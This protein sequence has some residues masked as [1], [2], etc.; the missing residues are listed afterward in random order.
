MTTLVQFLD[1][2]HLG[3]WARLKMDNGDPCWIGIAQTGIV[4]KKSK[5]GLLGAKLF[6]ESNVYEAGMTAMRLAQEYPSDLT[7]PSMHNVVL[8]AF[9]NAVMHCSDLAQVC[10][11]LN[12]AKARSADTSG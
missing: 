6:E 8:K 12:E 4:V 1:K 9:A 10:R 5:I 7:P 11:V 3:L 2:G